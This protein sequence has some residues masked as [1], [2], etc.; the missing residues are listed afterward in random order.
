MP[1]FEYN[2]ARL[3]Y[4][5]HGEGDPLLL[6][7][8]YT[9]SAEDLADL[10]A[11][12]AARY[13]VIAPDRRGYGRSEPR[14]KNYTATFYQ[15]DA[16]D[17]AALLEHLGTGPAHIMGFSDGGEVAL[18]IPILYPH[19]ARSVAAW[20][21][22]GTLGDGEIMPG[23]DNIYN[24]VD[25]PTEGMHARG[26][27]LKARYGEEVARG[28][29]HGWANAAKAI[30]AADGDISLSRAHEIRCPVLVMAGEHD[31][32]NPPHRLN[33]LASRIPH[34]EAI[35]VEGAGHALHEEKP[36][37]FERTVLDWLERET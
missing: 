24:M 30:L 4:E 20:G 22:V 36:E 10:I 34:G 12:L 33:E 3:H 21:A 28:M 13:R 29:A 1:W 31:T 7:H 16:H 8:G 9:D 6:M 23:V 35:V 19:L 37:W 14:P 25:N 11:V 27:A 26:E 32:F 15:D 18:L 5:E 17:M 2:G